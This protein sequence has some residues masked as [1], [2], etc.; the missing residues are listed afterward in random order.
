MPQDT[1]FTKFQHSLTYVFQY[2][3]WLARAWPILLAP[4]IP[5]IGILSLF[6]LKG[7]RFEMVRSIAEERNELPPVD[8]VLWLKRGAILWA[9]LFAYFLVPWIVCRLLGVSGI[10][11]M[12][13][14]IHLL[15]TEGVEAFI[16]DVG[17]DFLTAFIV[18]SVWALISA[19]TFQCG[20]VRYVL[21]GDWRKLFGFVPN[22]YF[23]LTNIGMFISFFVMWVLFVVSVFLLDFLLAATFVGAILIPL[24][25][26]TLFYVATAHELGELALKVKRAQ[27]LH[28]SRQIQSTEVTP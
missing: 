20:M 17:S 14:D 24:V 27:A 25:T 8:I 9:A 13:S 3:N 7:W 16:Q 2:P 11:D 15:F 6:L 12:I 1:V 28:E 10:F 4:F 19:P 5:I 26:I 18:Y 22:V 23:V 21:S